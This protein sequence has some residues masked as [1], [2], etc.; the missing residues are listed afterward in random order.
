MNRNL[1]IAVGAAAALSLNLGESWAQTGG[2]DASGYVY[3]PATYGFVT[4]DPASGGPGTYVDNASGN[5]EVALPFPFVFYGTGYAEVRVD[6]EPGVTMGGNTTGLTSNN[7]PLPTTGPNDPDL[8][9]F[10]DN[11]NAASTATIWSWYD[12]ANARLI[13]SWEGHGV[14]GATEPGAWQVHLG[15]DH[16]I[17]YHYAD[18]TFGVG[19][20]GNGGGT[21]TI[22][23]QDRTGGTSTSGNVLLWSHNQPLIQDGVTAI[24]FSLCADADGD[25]RASPTCGGTDCDDSNGSTYPGAPEVCD[26][27]DNDCDATTSENGDGDGDGVSVCGGDCDDGDGSAYP[28]APE[29]CDGLDNDCDGAPSAPE[30]ID[31]DGD[32]SLSCIDCDDASAST[33]PG[34]GEICDGLDND[35]DGGV[36]A[37]ELVDGDG[38][39]SLSCADCDDANP[40]V[41]P[42]APELCDGLDTNCNGALP[43]E[44]V[45]LDGDLAIFCADCDD[46]DPNLRPGAAESCDGVDQDCDG[47]VAPALAESGST[48]T[49]RARG[50]LIEAAGGVLTQVDVKLTIAVGSTLEFVVYERLSGAGTYT[51]ISSATMVVADGAPTWHESPAFAVDLQA[52]ATYAIGAYWS[53]SASYYY[54]GG[55]FPDSGA[56]GTLLGSLAFSGAPPPTASFGT[57]STAYQVRLHTLDEVDVD[58]DSVLTCLGDC[59]DTNA[60]VFPGAPELC[61]GL[62]GDCDGAVPID[63]QDLDAD[64]FFACLGDCDDQYDLAYPGAPE[65]CD[66]QDTDCDGSMAQTELVDGDNDGSPL[67]ADCDDADGSVAPGNTETCDGVDTDCDGLLDGQDEDIGLLTLL[68]ADLEANDGGFSPSAASGSVSLFEYG[69]PQAGPNTTS[70]GPTSG[71]AGDNVWGTVLAGDYGVNNNAAYLTLPAVTLPATGSPSF[72]F[73]YWQDNESSCQ[74]DFG[75]VMISTGGGFAPLADGDGCASGLADTNGD[76]LPVSIDLTPYRGSTVSLR[77]AHTTDVSVTDYP[78]LYVDEVYVRVTDDDDG[79]GWVGC[80]DCDDGSAAVNPDAAEACDGLDTDCDGLVDGLDIDVGVGLLLQADLDAD[81]GGLVPSAQAGSVGLFEYGPPQSGPNASAPG[82]VLAAS[83]TNVWGTVLSGNYGVTNNT[84]YLTLPA[85]TLP[86]SGA[87]VLEFSYWQNNEGSCAGDFGGLQIDSGSGFDPLPDGDACPGGLADTGGV[88]AAV[89]VDLTSHAGSTITLRFVHT[90]DST[91]SSY[92]GL[93]IDDI[94]V[95]VIDDDDSDGWV[96]C[97]DCDDGNGAVFPGATEICDGLDG[98]C[99]GQVPAGEA[100]GDGDGALACADCDDGAATIYPGAPELCNGVDDD[101][102]GQPDADEVDGDGDGAMVCGGDCDDG[103]PAIGPAQPEV[104]DGL[105][106]DCSG[107]LPSNEINDLDGDGSIEC[108]DC[109]DS[110]PSIFPGAPELCN[111]IDDDCSGEPDDPST[112]VPGEGTGTVVTTLANVYA[113]V[114]ATAPIFDLDVQFDMTHPYALDMEVLLTSPAGT[115]VELFTGVGAPNTADFIGTVLDDEASAPIAGAAAPFTGSFQPEGSL[116][117]FDGENPAGVWTLAL[118]DTFAGADDGL[119]NSWALVFNEPSGDGDNDGYY[120]CDDCDDS[121]GSVYPGAAEV[122]DGLDDDCDGQLPSNEADADSDGVSPCDG[123]CDDG[124]AT[125]F[126]GAVDMCGD[127]IDQDCVGGDLSCSGNPGD[128]VI[129]EVMSIPAAVANSRGEWIELYNPTNA[130]IMLTGWTIAGSG[131][132]AFTI[133]QTVSI[134]AGGFAV[135]AS[136]SDPNLNGGVAA[137]FDWPSGFSLPDSGASTL[138]LL[139]GATSI[140]AIDLVVAGAPALTPG[141]SASLDPDSNTAVAN[142]VGANWLLATS[143]FGSGDLGTPGA[144]NDNA[145]TGV[146]GTGDFDGDGTCNDLDPDDDGDGDPDGSDCDDADASI[147]TGAPEGCDLI[148]TDCDGALSPPELDADGDGLQPCSGDCDDTDASVLPGATEICDAVDQDCDGD[149]LEGFADADGDGVPDCVDDD[150]D[151]DGESSSTDCD[152]GDPAIYTGA[153]EDCDGVDSDCDGAADTDDVDG[154]GVEWCPGGTLQDCDDDDPVIYTGAPGLCDGKDNDCSGDDDAAEDGD[155]DGS[156]VCDDCDDADQTSYPGAVEQCDAVD[157][158]CDGDPF[159]GDGQTDWYADTDGDGFGDPE[160]PHPDN[161]LCLQP[162][163]HVADATDCDDADPAVNPDA[164]EICDGIDGD[165][166]PDTEPEGGELDADGDGWRTCAEEEGDDIDCDDGDAEAYPDAVERCDTVEDEDCDGSEAVINDDP[167]CWEPGCG[168]SVASRV[169]VGPSALA[170]LLVAGLILRRRRRLGTPGGVL[171]IALCLLLP[172]TSLAGNMQEE[173]KRQ[174]EFA[175][176]ELANKRYDRALKSAESALRLCPECLDVMVLKAAAYFGL[177]ERKLAREVMLA[178]VEEVGES[179]L[180]LEAQELYEKLVRRR[181]R[182]G[183]VGPGAGSR[184]ASEQDPAVYRERVAEALAAERCRAARSAAGE[185]VSLLPE[186]PGAWALAGDAARCSDATREAVLAYRKHVALGGADPAVGR[187][188]DELAGKLGS[189][190]VL[191]TKPDDVASLTLLLD[192]GEEF[193]E[194]EAVSGGFQFVDIAPE[195]PL[196]LN[197]VGTGVKAEEVKVKPLRSAEK[198]QLAVTPIVVGFGTVS[199]LPYKID[200]IQASI[201]GPEGVVAARPGAMMELTVGSYTARVESQNGMV[202]IPLEITRGGLQTFDANEHEPSAITV[203]GL[204]AGALVRVFVEGVGGAVAE[205]QFRVPLADAVLDKLTGVLVAPPQKVRNLRPGRGGLFVEHPSLGEGSAEFVLTSGGQQVTEFDWR[206]LPGVG[207]V[208]TAF[209][210]WQEQAAASKGTSGRTVAMGA[211]SGGLLAAGVVMFVVGGVTGSRMTAIRDEAI[212][213]SDLRDSEALIAADASFKG[214]TGLRTA[215]FVAGSVSAGLG[216]LGGTITIATGGGKGK[217]S[218][219]GWD[220][221]ALEQRPLDAL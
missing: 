197:V 195:R 26:G 61:D 80:G 201:S 186:D 172:A 99:D 3:A 56:Y 41:R 100:D 2:P 206:A 107:A 66:G 70:P 214:Q 42:G 30:L 133:D 168:A 38:D 51:L 184:E 39:G 117:A 35:C 112:T 179:G 48:G 169:R 165:C 33:Y 21:A 210:A 113:T 144:V 116:A 74:W 194:G 58:G 134:P 8:A 189:V 203:G 123:D 50:L 159:N 45:D 207:K 34:A 216:V 22:G 105:D 200:H 31:A 221:A 130:P 12:A 218:V 205:Q 86:T 59:D 55:A 64:T 76:W 29:I 126:P 17:E 177:G 213:A 132:L 91:G 131:S 102:D 83:G 175:R 82:P 136:D 209:A 220:P 16:S 109:V 79:D 103:D 167:E 180:S 183:A 143:T 68:S 67:C 92:P 36:P 149:V 191:V 54:A 124:N 176:D 140:D 188:L 40:S 170:L 37:A 190:L 161:P 155:G 185:L 93:Y 60:T 127:G 110:D 1:L 62:D 196:V 32:G 46:T 219:T 13:L 101:C 163:D 85:V 5:T 211:A 108:A 215:M 25:G 160:A 135:L 145:C 111:A 94:S 114:T 84:A 77:F 98:D 47:L 69:V 18:T 81:D 217:T 49:D 95:R 90:S 6:D 156:A 128:V 104:C 151:G 87:P 181:E 78:G 141:V 182:P 187:H 15:A 89:S 20:P 28:G 53:G 14:S 118:N 147:Y 121:N 4:L 23:I 174:M 63:E 150:A 9:V 137:D 152:D 71:F 173:A 88:W 120:A 122:C 24:R 115:T 125:V 138:E 199:I 96:A 162:A 106:T 43:V 97:G 129:N 72:E 202:A 171:V 178:Y 148:D 11:I 7:Q 157:H 75:S 142:D 212:T 19:I 57:S 158:D 119:L 166:D 192:T 52:G 198:R 204:P 27:A 154:D 10:W 193:I 146:D 44:E 139:A 65:L 153:P 73:R 164:E 208:T